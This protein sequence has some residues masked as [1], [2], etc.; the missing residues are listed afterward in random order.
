MKT[1]LRIL[2]FVILLGAAAIAGYIFIDT[3]EEVHN[4][5]DL[6]PANVIYAVESDRPIKDWQDM[7]SSEVWR[8]LKG[9][10]SFLEI[11]EMADYLDSL[12]SA[13]QKLVDAV[14]LGD[15]VISAH[16]TSRENYD[17]LIIVDLKGK[18]RKLAKLKP[19]VEETFSQLG[20]EVS[21]RKDSFPFR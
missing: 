6:V 20:Y 18:G 17:F 16:M 7:S 9:N 11:T 21:S 14:R 1:V 3:G 2:L 8:Y 4:P 19:V 12:L 10:E 13:N 15:M 5:L